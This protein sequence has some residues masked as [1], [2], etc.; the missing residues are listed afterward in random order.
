MAA[1]TGKPDTANVYSP[2]SGG[3][4]GALARLRSL[5]LITGGAAAMYPDETLAEHAR[6]VD[7]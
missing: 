6:S 5:Q 2:T 7:A 3:F 1:D 4:N